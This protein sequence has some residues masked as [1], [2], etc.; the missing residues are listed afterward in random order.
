MHVCRLFRMDWGH[1]GGGVGSL[2]WR[3][4]G[5]VLDS[6]WRWKSVTCMAHGGCPVGSFSDCIY[7]CAPNERNCTQI[8]LVSFLPLK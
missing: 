3:G 6:L 1:M 5:R 4:S 8:S 7:N 2:T